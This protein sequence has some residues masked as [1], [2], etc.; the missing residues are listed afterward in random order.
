MPA[1]NS[2]LSHDAPKPA[3]AAYLAYVF[4]VGFGLIVLYTGFGYFKVNA[5][6]SV[7]GGAAIHCAFRGSKHL[8]GRQF[9]GVADAPEK[10]PSSPSIPLRFITLYATMCLVVLLWYGLGYGVRGLEI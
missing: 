6:Y 4:I 1:S 9:A 10:T 3:S 8:W 5:L 2:D 7:L